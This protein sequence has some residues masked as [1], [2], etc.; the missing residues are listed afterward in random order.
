MDSVLTPVD[1]IGQ[2]VG[3]V[4]VAITADRAALYVDTTGAD[5]SKW[6]QEAP[7]GFARSHRTIPTLRQGGVQVQRKQWRPLHWGLAGVLLGILNVVGM[8]PKVGSGKAFKFPF[9]LELVCVRML[10]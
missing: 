6:T 5:A 2:T 9:L 4:D 1:L 10:F 7:A 8:N 3:P